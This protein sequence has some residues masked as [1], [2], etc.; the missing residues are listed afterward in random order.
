MDFT[1]FSPCSCSCR[2]SGCGVQTC[3]H[4]AELWG[5]ARFAAHSTQPPSANRSIG[6]MIALSRSAS[7]HRRALC[8]I[9]QAAAAAGSHSADPIPAAFILS[10]TS[11][12]HPTFVP[13]AVAPRSK[14][15]LVVW[16]SLRVVSNAIS[17]WGCLSRTPTAWADQAVSAVAVL[18]RSGSDFL[19]IFTFNVCHLRFNVCGC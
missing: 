8:A 13:A 10:M 15:C 11:A 14:W 4:A 5:S 18:V 12:A 19:T 17:W 9:H 3:G 6:S 2:C 7:R 16:G 1:R